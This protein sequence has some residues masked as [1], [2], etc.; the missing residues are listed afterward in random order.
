[1]PNNTFFSSYK[2]THQNTTQTTDYSST[3]TISLGIIGT[4]AG[5][6]FLGAY[7]YL[8]FFEQNRVAPHQATE[9]LPDEPGDELTPV[10]PFGT[11]LIP[12]P[13]LRR[14]N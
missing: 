2:N 7:C 3:L 1:M 14:I 12:P 9:P 6:I 4:V 11:T 10:V 5:M 8:Y 13:S